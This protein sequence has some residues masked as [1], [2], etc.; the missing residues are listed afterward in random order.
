MNLRRNT[1]SRPSGFAKQSRHKKALFLPMNRAVAADLI[2]PVRIAYERIRMGHCDRDAVVYMAEIALLVGFLT[3]RGFGLL[4]AAFLSGVEKRLLAELD[5]DE[6]VEWDPDAQL[7]D[8]LG[9]VVNEYDKLIRETRPH[10][11]L[12]AKEDFWRLSTAS[13]SLA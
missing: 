11:I 10:A 12:E 7:I 9:V 5:R 3:E 1:G 13:R 6:T 4:E 8:E 2:L